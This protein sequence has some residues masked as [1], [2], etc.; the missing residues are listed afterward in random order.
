MYVNP[1]KALP[2]QARSP[3][4]ERSELQLQ[5]YQ[6][7]LYENIDQLGRPSVNPLQSLLTQ[8]RCENEDD[9]EA[10]DVLIIKRGY[11][12]P[13]P[14]TRRKRR[15]TCAPFGRSPS[16]GVV[17]A[18]M[19]VYDSITMEKEMRCRRW[20]VD[21][22]YTDGDDT[23]DIH[24]ISEV[25]S[26]DERSTIDRTTNQETFGE[27]AGGVEESDDGISLEDID[28]GCIVAG[29][30]TSR[31]QPQSLTSLKSGGKILHGS[32]SQVS[33]HME[34]Q[35]GLFGFYNSD[36]TQDAEAWSRSWRV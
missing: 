17:K 36:I 35:T 10:C 28:L 31:I 1:L 12:K 29:W 24:T 22:P 18:G 14:G 23:R 27:R 30:Q 5:N 8:P 16:G 32:H 33:L 34:N 3:F 20:L 9:G 15:E 21:S 4:R 26:C 25:P 2:F 11:E 19:P 7:S 6:T 13:T